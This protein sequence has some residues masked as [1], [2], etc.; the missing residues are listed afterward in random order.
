MSNVVNGFLGQIVPFWLVLL[1]V[2]VGA[3]IVLLVTRLT[4][5]TNKRF[6]DRSLRSLTEY[7]TSFVKHC[8]D[9][10]DAIDFVTKH[11]VDEIDKISHNNPSRDGLNICFAENKF[12]V[13]YG[14]KEFTVTVTFCSQDSE[15]CTLKLTNTCQFCSQCT[16]KHRVS[17]TDI[18]PPKVKKQKPKK[19]IKTC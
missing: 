3:A 10:V 7:V 17:I 14:K 16:M 11:I 1:S 12:I 4:N 13:K 5:I 18:T 2:V 8:I 6:V 15:K 9:G 19:E